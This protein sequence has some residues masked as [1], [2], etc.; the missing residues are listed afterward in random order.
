MFIE[1]LLSDKRVLRRLGR[2]GSGKKGVRGRF[3]DSRAG[4]KTSLS[5]FEIFFEIFFF[6]K[7]S[8]F[9]NSE[10][11]F[12][13]AERRET[14]FGIFWHVFFFRFCTVFFWPCT[15]KKTLL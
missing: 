10:F 3:M 9:D 2:H 5:V 4:S 12:F 6:L 8:L 14:V 15:S 1:A 7:F 11:F 13:F